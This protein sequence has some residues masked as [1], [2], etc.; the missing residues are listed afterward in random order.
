MSKRVTDSDADD[1]IELSI[2][3]NAFLECW[4]IIRAARSD[5][6]ML[7]DNFLSMLCLRESALKKLLELVALRSPSDALYTALEE[8]LSIETKSGGIALQMWWSDVA[9]LKRRLVACFKNSPQPIHLARNR[10]TLA[11]LQKIQTTKS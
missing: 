4:P 10:I 7:P 5:L 11:E 9:W 2:L 3:E 1:P 8:A 6:K